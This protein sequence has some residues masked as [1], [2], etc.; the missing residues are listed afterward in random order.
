MNMHKRSLPY[1]SNL[2]EI[3]TWAN[4]F[5]LSPYLHIRL[6]HELKTA[7]FCKKPVASQSCLSIF[8][9]QR[10][11]QLWLV[12]GFEHWHSDLSQRAWSIY[13]SQENQKNMRCYQKINHLICIICALVK[14]IYIHISLSP[15]K[16]DLFQI[17]L[18]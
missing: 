3:V 7:V 13:F 9:G 15:T 11:H 17:P 2:L 8:E 5:G 4:G 12:T 10:T 6:P 18:M 1:S 16:S 14:I